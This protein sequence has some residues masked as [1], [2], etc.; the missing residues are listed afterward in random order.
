MKFDSNH[1]FN[2]N[3]KVGQLF[4]IAV[5]INDTEENIQNTESLISEYHIGAL[6]FFHSRASAATNFEGKKKVIYNENSYERLVSL[7]KRY[8]KAAPTPLLIAI[9]AEWGLAMRIENTPQYPY[10][11]TL[12]ALY[13]KDNLIH[14]IGYA[15]GRDCLQAGIHWNLAPVLDINSNP[16]NPVIGYRSFG[17]DK[18]QVTQKAKAFLK[19]MQKA[20]ILN[21]L[22]H[23]PGHGD[24]S[25]DSHLALPVIDKSADS[26]FETELYPFMENLNEADSLM[27]GHLSVPALEPSGKPATLSKTILSD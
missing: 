13:N 3:Q 19:G 1:D 15:I 21:S 25:T 22:K 10:A 9:D 27:I 11:L 18:E 6:C 12:G 17:D 8:Q 7:I 16:E 14:Q 2:I 23:F 24:T 26:F 4:M 20:G 5:F